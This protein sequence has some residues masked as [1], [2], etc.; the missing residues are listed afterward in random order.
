V[1]RAGTVLPKTL[2]VCAW[3][4]WIVGAF[5][6]A[7]PYFYALGSTRIGAMAIVTSSFVGV[8]FG[9]IGFA[10]SVLSRYAG[11]E[12]LGPLA[13]VVLWSIAGAACFGIYVLA[14]LAIWSVI[15]YLI[16]WAQSG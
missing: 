10:F 3:I 4:C 7:L 13:K 11:K 1:I 9:V 5:Y 2:R 12:N 14:M 16:D 15:E 8:F 6:F